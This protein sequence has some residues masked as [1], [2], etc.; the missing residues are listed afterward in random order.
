M[1]AT[2]H[3]IG[4]FLRRYGEA[5][6]VGDLQAIVDCWGIPAL[7]LSD[8]SQGLVETK[9]ELGRVEHLGQRLV[10]VDVIWNALD[11]TGAKKSTEHSRYILST[12]VDGS[13]RIRVA[14]SIAE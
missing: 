13:L 4:E 2:E 3:T 12:D 14:I 9:H 1:P 5:L 6:S 10:S 7:V 11:Q 8:R